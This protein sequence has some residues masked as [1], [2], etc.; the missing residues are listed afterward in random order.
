[1]VFRNDVLVK[2]V[3]I[4]AV[5]GSTLCQIMFPEL[6]TQ[7]LDSD[8]TQERV[9]LYAPN[10][11]PENQLLYPGYQEHDWVCD[12]GPTYIYYPPKDSCYPAY[13]QGPCKNGE[14]LIIQPGDIIPSCVKNP[15]EDGFA[16][17]KGTCYEMGRP[18]GPCRPIKEGGGIFDVNAT[19]LV[20]HCLKGTDRLSLFSLPKLC[21]PGSKR[22]SNG[23]CRVIYN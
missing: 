23:V 15:C 9:P 7:R 2:I 14:H 18:N 3:I 21:T 10:I 1:M 22:D 20:V 11:C 6:P 19:N 12:C 5:L 17:Y 8:N 16:R 13:R 4:S